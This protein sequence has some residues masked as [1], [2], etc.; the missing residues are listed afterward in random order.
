M[1]NT[2]DDSIKFHGAIV[3]LKE[4]ISDDDFDVSAPLNFMRMIM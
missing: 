1:M 4:V 3:E 2:L